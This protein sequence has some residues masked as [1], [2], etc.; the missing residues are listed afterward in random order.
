MTASALLVLASNRSALAG[1]DARESPVD[2]A[3]DVRPLLAARCYPCHGPDE[4]KREARL[5]LDTPEGLAKELGEY[6]LLLPGAPAQSELYL[7]V[8][9]TD[10]DERMPPPESGPPL[11]ARELELLRRWIEE[12]APWH[13]HWAYAPLRDVEPPPVRDEAWIR[14][15]IDRFVLARL[16]AEGLAP[17]PPADRRSLLR[18][19]SLDLVGLPPTLGQLEAFLADADEGAYERAVEGLL[20]SPHYA[21]RWARH[22]LDLA[23]YADSHG[24]TIDGGRSMWP[25][26]DW[27]IRAIDADMPFDRFT[28]EQ[29]AGDLLPEPTNAQLVATGFQRNT[30]TNQEGGAK[31]EEN[32]VNAVFDRVDTTGAVWLGTTLGCARCHSHKFDPITQTEY[33]QLFAFYNQSEDGGV[34][35][36]PSVLVTDA[37]SERA[38]GDYEREERRLHGLFAAAGATARAGWTTWVPARATGSNG[39]ELR[40]EEDASIRSIGHNPQTSDYVLEGKAPE[41]G[42]SS[43]RLEALPDLR[44]PKYGP[45]RSGSGNFVLERVRLYA[46]S[47]A[48]EEVGP[49]E[50]LSFAR[51]AADYSQGFGPEGGNPYPVAAA[52]EDEPRRGWAVSPRFGTPHVAHFEL[53]RPLA[54]GAWEMRVVLEQNWGASHVL[55]RLRLACAPPGAAVAEPQVPQAWSAAWEALVAHQ[56]ERP[57]LPSSLVMREREQPRP[58]RVFRRGNFLDPGATVEPGFPADLNAF[59]PAARPQDR[60]D[61][62]RWLVDPR[63]ALVQRVTV[64]RWWQQLFGLGLVE[65]ENDFGLRGSAPD[66]PELLEW[67][68]REFVARDF[69]RKAL[70]RLIVTSATYRQSSRPRA[71]L[72]QRDP[73]NRLLARQSRLRVEAEVLRDSALRASGLLSPEVGGPP[74]QP[75]QP[76][77]VF[78][79]TQSMKSWQATEGTDRYRRTL[80]TRL[81]RS[82]TYP[83]LLTFDAPEANVTCT[84]RARSSTA[85]QALTLANDPMLLEL[86]AGLGERLRAAEAQGLDG[87]ARGFELCLARRPD[88]AER[89]LLR[90]HHDSQLQRQLA[91]GA[92]RAAAE[93]HAWT[94]VARVLFNLDEFLTR[95]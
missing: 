51:A 7:R 56:S 88:E 93:L 1:Q 30:Q 82:S 12:G 36:E 65:T 68:A 57:R 85:L 55:G 94:A 44:L 50:E 77:G 81:W 38:L 24:Y 63:N 80:Y 43:L 47:L 32:R 83:F 14:N 53:A 4:A 49:F 23:R 89:A 60:L 34:S 11:E 19:V 71:E 37:E 87:C 90:A 91:A 95:E 31:D 84:R 29:L 3:R 79:F 86:A 18:R 73:H 58:N 15:P 52:L 21:E 74:V 48:A 75:P 9:A 67:L 6:H 59:A 27:V 42:L 64:N 25:W 10:E 5:R 40:I 54:P 46:R 20:A 28:I 16:E 78:A 61:L 8:S 26:R 13:A 92:E 45:G 76:E 69:S 22:W 41:D 2:F 35:S 66:H 62:A 70:L 39:P 17:A 33:F 72:A